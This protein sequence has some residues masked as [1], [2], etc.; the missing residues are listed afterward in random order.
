[1]SNIT[2]SKNRELEVK[3]PQKVIQFILDY[4]KSTEFKKTQY[5]W[6]K[7]PKN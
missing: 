3:P 2:P 7:T 5:G 1:M 6:V 4:S